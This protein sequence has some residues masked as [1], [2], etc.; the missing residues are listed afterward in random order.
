MNRATRWIAAALVVATSVAFSPHTAR[1]CEC[2][3]LDIHAAYAAADV[4]FEGNAVRDA[5]PFGP[6]AHGAEFE[7]VSVWKGDVPSTVYLVAGTYDALSGAMQLSSCDIEPH[8][9][10]FYLVFAKHRDR[11]FSTTQC[12]GTA[13]K[14]ADSLWQGRNDE[15]KAQFGPG[16]APDP[17][18]P[19]HAPPPSDQPVGDVPT[20]PPSAEL[21]PSATEAAVATADAQDPSAPT[22]F[23]D[24]GPKPRTS[25]LL[26]ALVAAAVAATVIGLV[27]S[28]RHR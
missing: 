18:L 19:T 12:S 10:E 24:L 15:L 5:S 3:E 7:V 17:A 16:T 26:P 14:I 2:G 20:A 6:Y 1:A 4:V 25:V 28:W 9:G 23:D 13:P 21:E 8:G 11:F 27:R 22:A